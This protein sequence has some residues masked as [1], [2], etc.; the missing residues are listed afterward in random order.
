MESGFRVLSLKTLLL[1]NAE[2]SKWMENSN[3]TCG[4]SSLECGSRSGEYGSRSNECRRRR[5]YHVCYKEMCFLLPCFCK[6]EHLV[7]LL[8]RTWQFWYRFSGNIKSLEGVTGTHGSL[9]LRISHQTTS[10]YE[11]ITNSGYI[12]SVHPICPKWKMRSDDRCHEYIL[13][14]C[15]LTFLYFRLT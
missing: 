6:M 3:R 2:L 7:T 15:T 4:S 13:T 8:H 14:C 12:D 5:S 11:Y 10:G 1:W 9:S